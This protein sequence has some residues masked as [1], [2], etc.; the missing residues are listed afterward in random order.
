MDA[1]KEASNYH[2]ENVYIVFCD[3]NMMLWQS[4]DCTTLSLQGFLEEVNE[5]SQEYGQ[6]SETKFKKRIW[7]DHI[8]LGNNGSTNMAEQKNQKLCERE[9]R[10][11]VIKVADNGGFGKHEIMQK[12]KR[13]ECSNAFKSRTEEVSSKFEL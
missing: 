11:T 1:L 10:T 7:S 8:A 2:Q 13:I 5:T 12:R 6:K 9:K 3:G 4:V